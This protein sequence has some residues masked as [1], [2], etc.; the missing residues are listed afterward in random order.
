M[1]AEV[2]RLKLENTKAVEDLKLQ[3]AVLDKL[4]DAKAIDPDLVMKSGL[5]DK[6]KLT[7]ND[8]G[9]LTGLDE[10]LTDLTKNKAFLFKETKVEL[11]RVLVKAV[12][13]VAVVLVLWILS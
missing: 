5:I 13:V 3:Y 11:A 7:Y 4:R 10:Q 9:E 2:D 8:K 1:K 6:T 12:V